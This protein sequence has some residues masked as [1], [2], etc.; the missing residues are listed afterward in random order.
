M[1]WVL[2]TWF[3]FWSLV[4]LLHVFLSLVEVCSCQNGNGFSRNDFP[5][6]FVFGSGSSAYQ[7]EGAADEDG[8]TPSVWDTFTHA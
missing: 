5:T 2:C 6:N 8:K 3:S 7:V 4:I 1:K